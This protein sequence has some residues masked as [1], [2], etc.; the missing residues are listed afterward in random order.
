[1]FPFISLLI[2]NYSPFDNLI[3]APTVFRIK[4]DLSMY[5]H[6]YVL[7]Y[8]SEYT[9]NFAKKLTMKIHSTGVLHSMYTQPLLTSSI[10]I[11]RKLRK[12]GNLTICEAI[13]DYIL[14]IK[15]CMSQLEYPSLVNKEVTYNTQELCISQL[16]SYI[17]KIY[18]HLST[19]VSKIVKQHKCVLHNYMHAITYS[20]KHQEATYW[21]IQEC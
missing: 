2:S 21:Y 6:N 16:A 14:Y 5:V 20:I 4:R 10:K 13:G 12:D 3:E 15:S 9:C 1:M 8:I 18:K 17:T 7:T 11:N 19:A